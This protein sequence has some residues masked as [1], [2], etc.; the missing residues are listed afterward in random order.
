MTAVVWNPYGVK[1]GQVW[2]DNDKRATD[3][4]FRI[5]KLL[6]GGSTPDR[7]GFAVVVMLTPKQVRGRE[8]EIRL[9]R[10]RPN[11]TGYRLVQDVEA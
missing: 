3:R 1:V 6:P 4:T 9:D 11:S 7:P 2:R 8:R 10:F 5:R